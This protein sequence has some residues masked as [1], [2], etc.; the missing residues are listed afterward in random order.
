MASNLFPIGHLIAYRLSQ[1]GLSFIVRKKNGAGFA[2]I[3]E[4][5]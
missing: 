4:V 5:P 1:P 3:A 2:E